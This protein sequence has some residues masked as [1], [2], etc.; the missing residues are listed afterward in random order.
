MLQLLI[1]HVRVRGRIIL[2]VLP[3]RDIRPYINWVMLPTVT[4][5]SWW[6]ILMDHKWTLCF[7]TVAI[8]FGT[9]EKV[10]HL[11]CN[12]ILFSVIY[13]IINCLVTIAI[14]KYTTV[15]TSDLKEFSPEGVGQIDLITH[16]WTRSVYLFSHQQGTSST[17]HFIKDCQ[18][19]FGDNF[20]ITCF[21]EQKLTWYASTLYM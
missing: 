7:K 5:E 18:R 16:I 21:F 2:K 20:A 6:A 17:V 15:G 19:L 9:W 4:I 12:R 1:I 3:S 11:I 14:I 8:F 13:E 10:P